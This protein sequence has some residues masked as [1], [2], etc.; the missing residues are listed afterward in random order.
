MAPLL[1]PDMTAAAGSGGAMA[2]AVRRA[3]AQRYS[4]LHL[5]SQSPLTTQLRCRPAEGPCRP[6]SCTNGMPEVSTA[7]PTCLCASRLEMF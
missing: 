2:D 7:P 5:A 4:P 6:H 3:T 1:V